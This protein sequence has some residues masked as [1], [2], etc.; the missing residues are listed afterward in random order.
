VRDPSARIPGLRATLPGVQA[1]AS[2][3]PGLIAPP[4]RDSATTPRDS[5][6]ALP[7]Y[8]YRVLGVFDQ[9][10]GDVIDG[11]RV[12]DANTGTYATTSPT[13]TVSLVFLPEGSSLVRITRAG[14]EDLNLSVDIGPTATTPLT[15]LMK[16]KP[17]DHESDRAVDASARP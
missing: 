7:A 3:S 10:T 16:K 6:S 9:N 17:E 8:R 2:P 4:A 14:Y 1:T 13:G 5:V 12:I 15:L 11:A